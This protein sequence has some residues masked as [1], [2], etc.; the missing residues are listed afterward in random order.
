M[1]S[2]SAFSAQ[3][4]LYNSSLA[5][6]AKDMYLHVTNSLSPGFARGSARV[7]PVILLKGVLGVRPRTGRSYMSLIKVTSVLSRLWVMIG[8]P[9]AT[10][11]SH[12]HRNSILGTRSL[13]ST[14]APILL[15]SESELRSLVGVHLVSPSQFYKRIQALGI[16][17][18]SESLPGTFRF[19]T[20]DGRAAQPEPIRTREIPISP[21]YTICMGTAPKKSITQYP[22]HVDLPIHALCMRPGGGRTC[23]CALPCSNREAHHARESPNEYVANKSVW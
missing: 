17:V 23:L 10:G 22:D 3:K 5:S 6:T 13:H 11:P 15:T 1:S 19:S 9:L 8:M 12:R 20:C 14:P 4:S 21:R 18:C 16:G 2:Y 7:Y